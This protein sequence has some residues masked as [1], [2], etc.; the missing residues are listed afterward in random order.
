MRFFL[1]AIVLAALMPIASRSRVL[2]PTDHR[3]R[4]DAATRV[5]GRGAASPSL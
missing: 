3:P 2:G 5:A 1:V 4:S